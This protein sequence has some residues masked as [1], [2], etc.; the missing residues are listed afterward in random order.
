MGSTREYSR[1]EE[2]KEDMLDGQETEMKG[3]Y[4]IGR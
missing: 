2:S 4:Q 3:E 1:R